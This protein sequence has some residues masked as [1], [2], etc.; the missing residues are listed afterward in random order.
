VTETLNLL[1][2]Q[3]RNRRQTVIWLAAFMLFFAWIG[4]GGDLVLYLGSRDEYGQAAYRVPWIG[5]V[6]TLIAAIVARNA[7][8]RG[9]KQ[10]LW[11][12][13]GVELVNPTTLEEKQLV[14][15]VEEMAI[16]AGLPRPRVYIVE[17]PDPNA[18]ATGHGP[19]TAC[20][21]VTRGL[22]AAL[23][24]EEIQA[25]VGHEMGHVRNLDVRLMTLIAAL[26]GVI[27]LL[28]DALG[29]F[30]RHGGGR[31]LGGGRGRKGGAG[32][33]VLVV[34]VLWIITLILAPLISR[35]MAMAVSRNREYLADATAAELTRNPA[36]LASALQKIESAE[37]PTKSIKRST[38]HL[39][40]ADPLG[41]RVNAKEGGMANLFGTHPPMAKRIAILRG[42]AYQQAEA[43]GDAPIA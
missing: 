8:A 27:V 30:L 18:F 37:A 42:M 35:L 16:A 40:I 2:Q 1:E 43:T 38:A 29:R 11:A 20:V 17:D 36:A 4:F 13:G 22:L 25:V 33:L 39:C 19:E 31:A 24:R 28:S 41:R 6:V 32:G 21:A 23:N 3:Q 10:V 14:N 9:P 5:L 15:V 34:L 12:A 7:W 26:V